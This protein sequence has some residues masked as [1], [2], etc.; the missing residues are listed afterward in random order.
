VIRPKSSNEPGVQANPVLRLRHR[1]RTVASER[2]AIYLPVIRRKYRGPSPMVISDSTEAVID[3]YTRSASTFTVYAFQLSQ[4]GPVR[5]AHHLHAPAQ[6]IEAARRQL[7][8][9]VVLREPRGA[10]LSQLV[11]EPDVDMRDALFGYARFHKA[12]V[13]YRNSFVIGL[14]PEVTNDL[15]AVIRRMNQHFGTS[16]AEFGHSE[17]ELRQVV[18]LVKQRPTLSPTLLGF[19]SGLVT[20]AE[21]RA[22]LDAKSVSDQGPTGDDDWVPSQRR[23]NQKAALHARWESPAMAALRDSAQAAYEDFRARTS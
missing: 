17:E 5:L 22:M 9:L 19:E 11:R 23:E 2:P 12:L 16:Y 6:L 20:L 3:G 14:Y 10:I 4:P 8:T 7:P 13:P 18:E 21:V 15:G 1:L